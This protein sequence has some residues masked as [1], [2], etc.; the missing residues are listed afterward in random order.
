MKMLVAAAA[1]LVVLLQV[2]PW[3]AGGNH[4]TLWPAAVL[5]EFLKSR[6]GELKGAFHIYSCTTCLMWGDWHCMQYS[7]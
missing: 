6:E 5:N 2:Q 1:V 7:R 4:D 3:D